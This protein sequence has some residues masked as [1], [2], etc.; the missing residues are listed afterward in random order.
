M[1]KE[2]TQVR[3]QKELKEQLD[4]VRKE[5]IKREGKDVSYPE[6]FRR[7]FRIPQ[8]KD[9]LIEDAEFKGRNK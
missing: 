3:I 1:N 2:T 8:L 9:V 7:T 5:M 6:L 4:A